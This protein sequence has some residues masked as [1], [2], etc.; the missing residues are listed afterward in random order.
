[1][2]NLNG[3]GEIENC[4]FPVDLKGKYQ[5]FT[6]ADLINLHSAGYNKDFFSL[7]EGLKQYF[8]ILK[9]NNGL[10]V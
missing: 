5:E 6:E 2:R 9:S 3:R 4:E 10:F 8:D 1:M 7:E